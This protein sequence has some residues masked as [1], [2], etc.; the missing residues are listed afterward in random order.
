MRVSV[1]LEPVSSHVS[2]L[3]IHATVSVSLEPVSSNVSVL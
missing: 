2:V 3:L 1:F